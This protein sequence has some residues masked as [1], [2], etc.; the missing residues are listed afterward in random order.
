VIQTPKAQPIA[1][2]ERWGGGLRSC[3]EGAHCRTHTGRGDASLALCR[4]WRFPRRCTTP[5]CC[6]T[7][8]MRTERPSANDLVDKPAIIAE[9]VKVARTTCETR[10][11]SRW[12]SRML[13]RLDPGS[14][15]AP[16]P[17]PTRRQAWPCRRL[18]PH[19]PFSLA[20]SDAWVTIIKMT[21]EGSSAKT[22]FE[23]ALLKSCS[24]LNKDRCLQTLNQ[25]AI[26]Q[27]TI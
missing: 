25:P 26:H 27:V 6:A 2:R 11:G 10:G 16:R 1:R 14:D 8:K 19:H 17:S 3:C 23:H 21:G 5:S 18:P 15:V 4:R 13:P 12:R 7:I 20:T 24:L 22:D 9:I